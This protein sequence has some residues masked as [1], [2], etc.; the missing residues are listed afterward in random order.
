MTVLYLASR[1]P[2]LLRSGIAIRQFELLRAYAGIGKVR[3]AFLHRTPE[4]LRECQ[5]LREYC[6]SL[7]PVAASTTR[8]ERQP[9]RVPRWQRRLAYL[10]AARPVPATLSYSEAL[11]DL[12][13]ELAP[14]ADIV[15]VTR[16]HMVAHVELLLRER[17]RPRLILDLD[18][19]ETVAR[20]RFLRAGLAGYGKGLLLG[21]YDLGRIWW[22]QRRALHAFDRVFVC[23]REDQRRLGRR[24]VTVMPNGADVP[25]LELAYRGSD[26]HTILY[27]GSL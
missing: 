16:L 2:Y 22:Y 11:Q 21:G 10:T 14:S 17:G 19:V 9:R 25:P 27:S 5:P 13:Q 1:A 26:G 7:H 15:H 12:V 18:E 23:S 20:A 24:N 3:L 4:E 8:H 6:S